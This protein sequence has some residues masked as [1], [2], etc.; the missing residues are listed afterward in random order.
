MANDQKKDFWGW[1]IGDSPGSQKVREFARYVFEPPARNE[2]GHLDPQGFDEWRKKRKKDSGQQSGQNVGSTQQGGG[3][4]NPVSRPQDVTAMARGT[5]MTR[6]TDMKKQ[7]NQVR[8]PSPREPRQFSDYGLPVVGA[9]RDFQG[10]E[11]VPWDDYGQN[12]VRARQS[13]L[14]G[15]EARRDA[16]GRMAA[17][18]AP[19]PRSTSMGRTTWDE[20]AP[21]WEGI[22]QQLTQGDA[23]ARSQDIASQGA[24]KSQ[25]L[26]S[27]AA[28]KAAELEGGPRLD[29]DIQEKFVSQLPDI[30]EQAEFNRPENFDKLTPLQQKR[31]YQDYIS[32]FYPGLSELLSGSSNRRSYAD[33]DEDIS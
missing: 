20:G 22:M 32:R 5:D 25:Q 14:S 3:N 29:T 10:T 17:Q 7:T 31:W 33:P 6:D 9:T 11:V 28:L 8:S 12:M 13:G 16:T 1:V 21:G 27:E 19:S 15:E 26:Q 23:A 4:F 24:L 2:K 18:M 30:M